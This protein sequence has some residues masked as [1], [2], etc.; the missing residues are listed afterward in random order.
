[1]KINRMIKTAF[2]CSSKAQWC[3]KILVENDTKI[4]ELI[5]NSE[6]NNGFEFRLIVPNLFSLDSIILRGTKIVP[7][8][9]Y[10][11][12]RWRIFRHNRGQNRPCGDLRFIMSFINAVNRSR[13]KCWHI[14]SRR[15]KNWLYWWNGRRARW[16]CWA[17]F[18][19]FTVS[20][21][22]VFQSHHHS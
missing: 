16:C 4:K 22:E 3:A 7:V 14:W 10:F 15:R 17:H 6:M 20:V 11:P 13:L 8:P 12:L 1:M 2:F 9:V 21:V 19:K 5:I 18:F